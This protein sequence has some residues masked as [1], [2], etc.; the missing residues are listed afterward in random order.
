V[1][2]A[3]LGAGAGRGA[4]TAPP[5]EPL[6]RLDDT[7]PP[8]EPP[9]EPPE[10]PPEDERPEPDRPEPDRPAPDPLEDELLEPASL[11]PASAGV[12]A[13]TWTRRMTITGGGAGIGL[14]VVAQLVERSD[15]TVRL[16]PA[17]SGP[18]LLARV[19]LPVWSAA[20]TAG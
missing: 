19:V 15:G 20:P 1:A 5:D 11:D 7:E 9:D 4:L 18:G 16:L 10:E 6:G 13:G 12:G 14:S 3:G 8:D 17:P 2:G